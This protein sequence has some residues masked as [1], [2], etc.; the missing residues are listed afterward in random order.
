M[1][2]NWR[3]GKREGFGGETHGRI[4]NGSIKA[5]LHSR[6]RALR[7]WM[8]FWRVTLF[9]WQMKEYLWV[10]Q[11]KPCCTYKAKDNLHCVND[12]KTKENM[13]RSSNIV[14]KLW[15]PVDSKGWELKIT[16]NCHFENTIHNIYNS[17]YKK[18]RAEYI[19]NY[20]LAKQIYVDT[21][22]KM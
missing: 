3:G 13:V 4:C 10:Y 11:R 20:I 16:K 2:S 7:R 18:S 14:C 22:Q 12:C 6:A 8:G 5:A 19:L 1:N 17:A 9:T 21:L 15:L